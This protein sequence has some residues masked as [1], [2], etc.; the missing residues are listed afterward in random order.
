MMNR[1]IKVILVALLAIGISSSGIEMASAEKTEK[2]VYDDGQYEIKYNVDVDMMEGFIVGNP[3]VNITNGEYTVTLTFNSADMIDEFKVNDVDADRKD[4]DDDLVE[5]TFKVDDLDASLAAKIY[6]PLS[7]SD[8]YEFNLTL[9]GK[10][11]PYTI[12][13]E[14]KQPDKTKKKVYDDGQ[15]EVGYTVDIEMMEN[16]I[17][18]NPI[19][20]ITNGEYTVTLTFN[21]AD[22][23]EGFTVNDVDADRKDLDDD[24]VEYT[25]KVDDLDEPLTA[26]IY[27]PLSP[28]DYYEFKLTLDTENIPFTEV[29]EDDTTTPV[30]GNDGTDGQGGKDGKDGK[31]GQSGKDGKDGKDGANVTKNA[32]DSVPLNGTDNN[33]NGSSGGSDTTGD[34]TNTVPVENPKTSDKA[35]ILLLIVVL[36]GS[37]MV[38]FRKVAFR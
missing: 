5:Y 25:F 13:D 27:I 28:S 34:T 24:L 19:V 36:V 29:E 11:I 23:I 1:I 9:D 4:L 10:D 22:M 16:F 3:I 26:K 32:D 35:P 6:I 17:V 7:P 20:N 18:G 33:G 2:K 30:P 37:G 15:Y 14:T 8:Y 31:D 12:I 38:A 21:S